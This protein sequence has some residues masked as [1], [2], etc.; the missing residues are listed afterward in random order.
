VLFYAKGIGGLTTEVRSPLDIAS[1]W[2]KIGFRLMLMMPPKA[3]EGIA[4]SKYH[5]GPHRKRS[6]QKDTTTPKF[7]GPRL[8]R[9]HRT[10]GAGLSMRSS[11][12]VT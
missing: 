9:L 5:R 1:T 6:T 10:I 2:L 8:R 4:V 12:Q 11:P 3:V 7:V